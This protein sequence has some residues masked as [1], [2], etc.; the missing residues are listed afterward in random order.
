MSLQIRRATLADVDALSAIAIAT[1]TETWGDSYP[2]QDLHRFLQDHYGIA[3]QRAELSD[4]R[5]A[6]WLLVDGATVVGYL[7]AGANTLPHAEARE[8]D[9]ELKRLYILAA[10]QN[11][12]HGARLMEAFL[13]WLDQPARRTLWVGVW[14]E[15]VGA[16][17]FYARYG[18][19]KAGEYDFI[20]GDSRDREFILRRP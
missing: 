8:G 19:L 20:V 14:E 7:A 4:P 10:H 16:Q 15:N 5:S 1:Y 11:G 6:I 13:R 12:G 18:C 9:V 3:P 17:R 2:P